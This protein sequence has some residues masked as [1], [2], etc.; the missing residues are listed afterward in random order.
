MDRFVQCGIG[1]VAVSLLFQ[2][3]PIAAQS[4][5][6]RGEI[7]PYVWLSGIDGNVTVA[8]QEADVDLGFDDLIDKTD[9]AGSIFG[10][11]NYG[12]FLF[13]GQY[14][15]F[16]LSTD[17]LDAPRGGVDAGGE[18]QTDTDIWTLAVGY[19]FNLGGGGKRLG[20]LVGA[21]EISLE[22][23]LRLDGLP[24]TFRRDRDFTDT[25]VMLL[26]EFPLSQRWRLDFPVS[27]GS[28]DSES[29]WELWPQ[30]R[31]RLGDSWAF[32]A[33]YRRLHYDI[34]DNANNKFDA[35][36]HGLTLGFGVQ[37]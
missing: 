35:A 16:D 9:A 8:G 7:T 18:L 21:R 26:P 1:V 23:R 14:D 17:E 11:L 25:V 22:N 32:R 20:V 2:A 24:T 29:T 33:G 30:L 6:W 34:E 4:S 27:F 19:Q 10:R 28:G 5:E 12:R 36:F 37:W 13:V 31:Y 15:R 3:A